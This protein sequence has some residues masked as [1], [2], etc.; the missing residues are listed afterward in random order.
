MSR[1]EVVLKYIEDNFSGH[2]AKIWEELCR[3]YISGAVVDGIPFKMARRWQG[4]ILTDKEKRETKMVE[5]DVV[6]ESFDGKHLLI[7]ECKWTGREDA[8]REIHRLEL[9]ASKLPFVKK[10]AIHLCLFL[11]ERP[12]NEKAGTRIYYPEDILG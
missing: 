10:Q 12:F 1:S 7:G 8:S 3:E 9:I 6:A 4:T 5:L 11:K 2:V